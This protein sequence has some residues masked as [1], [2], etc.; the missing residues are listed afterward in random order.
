MQRPTTTNPLRAGLRQQLTPEPCTIVIFGATGDLTQRKLLPALYNLALDGLLPGAFNIVGVARRPKTD[1]QFRKEML[2]GINEFSRNRPV[3]PQVWETFSQGI[4]YV[5]SEFHDEAGFRRLKEKLDQVDEERGTGHN[6]LY[7][8]ATPPDAYPLIAAN[9]GKVGMVSRESTRD[10]ER[11]K[12]WSRLVVEKPFGRDLRSAREL[13]RQLHAVF[14]ERQI[15]RIDHYLGKE[16]VQ[17]LLVFRFGNIIF[18]PIWNHRYIDNVQI[19]V[20]ENIGI[21]GRASYYDNAGAIRDMVQNH[22]MQ[23][24]CLVAM[25]PPVAFDADAVRDE[26]VKVL[27]GIHPLSREQV[28]T[29]TVRAQYSAGAINGQPVPGYCQEPGVNPD[30]VTETY[31]ALKLFVE[32]WRWAGVPFYLR[33]GKRLPKRSTEIALQF[34]QVPHLL[35][36]HSMDGLDANSLV[37]H[38]Q[39]DEG[40]TIKVASKIPG[41]LMRVRPVNMDFR[42]GT[43]FGIEPADAYER[44]LLDA[45][46]GDSTLFTRRDEVEQAWEIV[47]SII[48]GWQ[49]QAP[50]DIPK[51]EAGSWGPEEADRLI[52]RDGRVWRR[53]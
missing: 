50:V 49:E 14:S 52:A 20:A 34:K 40:T 22:M 2:T 27:R 16:T 35:F 1:E 36:R 11:D 53:L 19:T 15:Y 4:F 37:V 33:T 23:T 30:S 9:L 41:P 12:G 6:V 45:L 26:K 47:N 48:D 5:Q 10:P 25:E 21:E 17:N 24:L 7:Y 42:Y 8:M 28:Q 51:Y 38:I 32:N 44:L 46:L 31:V 13:N 29:R 43:S 18:E 3:Q 39:P